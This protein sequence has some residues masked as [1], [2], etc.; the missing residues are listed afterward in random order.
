MSK[1]DIKRRIE[2]LEKREEKTS[3]RPWIV[4]QI[5]EGSHSIFYIDGV[6]TSE[7]EWGEYVKTHPNAKPNIVLELSENEP[8]VP[9]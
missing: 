5:C 3:S 9:K 2:D 7:D 1:T 4:Q 8:E 6:E